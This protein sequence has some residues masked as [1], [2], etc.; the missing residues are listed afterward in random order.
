M[1]DL[2]NVV[3]ETRV[4]L[5][6]DC[7]KC[8]VVCPVARYDPQFNPRLIV[9]QALRDSGRGNVDEKVWSCINCGLCVERCN[10]KVGF[11][12][13][14]RSLRHEALAQGAAIEYS[15][16]RAP[17][18]VMHMM[19]HKDIRQN[20][21]NWLPADVEI[22]RHCDTAFFVGCAPYFDIL[23]SELEVK[24]VE[25]SKGAL[26]LLNRAQVPFTLLPDERCCGRDL[27]LL[28]D[29]D[30]FLALARANSVEFAKR[31]ITTIITSCPE[32]YYT[33]KVDYPKFLD[34]WDI[35]V[36][37]IS[38]V[39]APLIDDKQLELGQ[40][41][42]AVTYHDPCTLGRYSGLYDEPRAILQSLGGLELT[43]M[44][45]TREKALCCGASPW[46]FCGSVNKQIQTE[47]L[48]QADATGARL[49]VTACPKCLIHLTCAQ[50][51]KVAGSV[52]QI[53]IR[54]LYDIAAQSLSPQEISQ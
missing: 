6:L 31:G 36:R 3:T 20:R 18:A 11:T 29:V 43:E 34:D 10:Y 49:L 38:E 32:C 1:Q 52:C 45:D 28:G 37:H 48:N 50:N 17:Q 25:G 12:D 14:I 27:L 30:G 51:D 44:A 23:F 2:E 39:L 15:H 16:G 46:A 13:F 21:L 26:K 8:T 24:T 53:E 7:G 42:Q 54:D 33:L 41:S 22:A 40:F 5:C 47:R 35:S 9:Q 19:A 4:R